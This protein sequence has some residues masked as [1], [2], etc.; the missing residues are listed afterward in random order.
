MFMSAITQFKNNKE[1]QTRSNRDRSVWVIN[2]TD[3]NG[4]G[5]DDSYE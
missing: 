2:R 3:I 5:D 4:D 1:C